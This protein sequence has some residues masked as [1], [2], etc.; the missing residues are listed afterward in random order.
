MLTKQEVVE[1][2]SD[3]AELYRWEQIR[4]LKKQRQYVPD[5]DVILMGIRCIEA[6]EKIIQHILDRLDETTSS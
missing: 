6:Y 5:E 3:S 2:L 1:M 4:L